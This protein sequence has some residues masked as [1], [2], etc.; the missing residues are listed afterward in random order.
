MHREKHLFT[1]VVDF[2][3][4]SSAFRSASHGKRDRPEVREFEY[5]LE[6]R[7]LEIRRALLAGTHRWGAYREFLICDPKRRVIRAAPF[8]D[9]V[10]HH[11]IFRI[12][13]PV[14]RRGVRHPDGTLRVRRRSVRR[15]WRRIERLRRQLDAN[16][17]DRERVQAS[18]ASWF[19]LAKH[20]DAFRLSRA[21]FA[22]RDVRNVGK[23]LL[24]RTLRPAGTGHRKD[25]GRRP[26]RL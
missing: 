16:R 2:N 20:A 14:I 9:R 10:V 25:A 7:L 5:H 17:I 22:A 26:Y 13:D 1:H 8:R 6:T 12:L 3:N 11:A 4:L 23:R 21:I 24:V 18:L 15:L 19:G